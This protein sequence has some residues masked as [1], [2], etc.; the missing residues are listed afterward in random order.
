[1]VCAGR[2]GVYLVQPRDSGDLDKAGAGEGSQIQ[3]AQEC[4]F[5]DSMRQ[6]KCLTNECERWWMT[7]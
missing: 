3:H 5:V 1:M 6:G 4:S 7:R 2:L